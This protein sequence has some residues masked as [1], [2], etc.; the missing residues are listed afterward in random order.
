M[1]HTRFFTQ[2]GF[3]WN[4]VILFFLVATFAVSATVVALKGYFLPVN[5][6]GDGP[7][8]P[9]PTTTSKPP[10]T[11][12][13]TLSCDVSDNSLCA[14]IADIKSALSTA[15]YAG[16]LAYQTQQSVTC[17]PEGMF[18]AICEGVAKGV[19]K[20]GYALGYN[21][22]EGT[23]T[24]KDGYVTSVSSYVKTNGPFIYRGS[25]VSGD[26]GVIVFLNT[27]KD[28]ILV[29]PMKKSGN[30]WQTNLLLLGGTF[31]NDSFTT[32]SSSLLDFV[33]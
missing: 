25:L 18:I 7:T 8:P 2:S 17:D 19:V 30:T 3:S 27:P 10:A 6:S 22:S 1:K 14:V 31:G 26:K 11:P 20:Q 13:P 21:Q 32:L 9:V 15:N 12:V 29:F 24:S 28:H 33:Q 23:M 4:I 16:F 5:T